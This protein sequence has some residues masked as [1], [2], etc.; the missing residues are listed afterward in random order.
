[1]AT[2]HPFSSYLARG[3]DSVEIPS[4]AEHLDGTVRASMIVQQQ[5][6]RTLATLS[7]ECELLG[8]S[9][10]TLYQVAT[11][12][13][14]C[15]GGGHVLEALSGRIYNLAV[16]AYQLALNGFYDEA[17]NLTRSIGEIANLIS[18]SVVD[19]AALSEWLASDTQTRIRKFSPAKIRKALEDDDSAVVIADRDWYSDFCEKYTHVTPQTIPNLHTSTG[20][21]HVGGIHD[22]NGLR[23]VFDELA[24]MVASVSIFVSKYADLDDM[25]DDIVRIIRKY[26][27]EVGAK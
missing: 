21:G 22:P 23:K 6:K 20:H 11:C 10:S 13:R 14:K 2:E 26:E 24:T 4:G 8:T 5:S 16:S 15:F 27:A 19:K 1:M 9:L 3:T 17:L 18:L 7:T 25:F 12:H